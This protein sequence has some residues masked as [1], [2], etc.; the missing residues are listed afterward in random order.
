[1]PF[2]G[3]GAFSVVYNFTSDAAAGI[4][5]LA[6]RQDT[7][8]ADVANN[9]LS[10]VICKDGQTTVT[11]NIPLNTLTLGG[12]A[13]GLNVLAATGQVT[14][15]GRLITSPGNNDYIVDNSGATTGTQTVRCTTTGGVYHWGAENSAGG[16]IITGDSG[17]DCVVRG[18]SGI[19]FSG[20]AGAGMGMRLDAN[21]RLNV[22]ATSGNYKM[23][24]VDASDRTESTA[25]FHIGGNGYDVFHWLNA[26]AYYIGQNSA[27]RTLRMYSGATPTTGVELTNGA[28]S[29]ASTSDETQKDIIE[30]I[31]GALEKVASLRSVIGKY[32]TDKEGIRRPFLIAQDVQKVLPEAVSMDADGILSLRYSEI[33]PLLVAALK[34]ANERIA[35]LEAN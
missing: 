17:Y 28:T 11:A 12:A 10:N 29:W 34:E 27:S 13:I 23:Q 8:W 31:S 30:P 33:I 1:L 32:K 14:M 6:S 15:T 21:N 18:P 5:I 4:K 9:G 7:Q 20:N 26:T 16:G 35:A 22:G 25:Q 2:N 19:A 24:I 3:A